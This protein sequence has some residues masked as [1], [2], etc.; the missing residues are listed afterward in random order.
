V[1]RVSQP[2]CC[3]R[4]AIRMLLMPKRGR[5]WCS[6]GVKVI[7]GIHRGRA[8]GGGTLVCYTGMKAVNAVDTVMSVTLAN[9]HPMRVQIADQ[10]PPGVIY[11]GLLAQSLDSCALFLSQER[12]REDGNSRGMKRWQDVY[13]QKLGEG[14]LL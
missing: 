7:R 3:V 5:S 2:L 6:S 1:N 8:R 11:V 12:V 10:K 13:L 9:C 4:S 14:P